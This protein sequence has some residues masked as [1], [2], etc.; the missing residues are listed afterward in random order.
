MRIMKPVYLDYNATCPVDKEV[1]A[2]MQPF[3]TEYFGNPSSMHSYGIKTKTAI[4]NARRQVAALLACEPSEIIFTSGGSE[5]NNYAIK[6]I[7]FEHRSKGRHIISSSIEHPA[8]YEVCRY[9][10]RSGFE[11]SYL[12]VDEAGLVSPA[13]VKEAIREDTILIS[14]MHANNEVGTIQP[15]GEIA[16]IARSHD[17]FFHTDAAQ[18]AGKIETHVDKLGVDLLSIAG[19]KIYAPKGVG[20]LY[21]RQGVTL[22]KLI[23]GADHEQNLR[24]GTENV[25]EIVGLGK[26]CELAMNKLDEYYEHYKKTRDYLYSLLKENFPEIRLNG[27]PVKCL[28]NT[29]S[30]SFP[31]LEASTLISRMENVAA[32]AGAACHA[33]SIDIS[34]VLKA[35]SVPPEYAMGTIRFSTGRETSMDDIAKASEE[36]STLV[37]SLMPARKSRAA[38]SEIKKDRIRL[39]HYTHGLGCACKIQPGHLEKVLASVSMPDDPGVLVGTETS[40][41][42]CVYLLNDRQ[43]IVQSLDFFTPVVDDPYSFGAIAAANALSDIYAMGA[44]PLFALNI[45]GFPVNTLPLSVLEQILRGAADKARQAGISILG[46]HTIEDNEPKFGLVV[47]GL[48]DPQKILRNKGAEAGDALILTKPIGTGILATAL[49]RGLLNGEQEDMLVSIM[50]ELNMTAAGILQKYEVHAC[51]DVTGFGLTGHLREMS[52]ASGCN[53]SVYTDRIPFIDEAKN[54]AAA[55]IIPGGTFSNLEF[56]KKDVRF[57]KCSRTMQV[58]L[59]DAQTSGGLLAAVRSDEGLPI[60]NELREAGIEDAAIIGEFTGKG[61]GIISVF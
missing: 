30:V 23:H 7:A 60:L 37:A 13:S 9:L 21:I 45:V 25:L 57:G 10:E 47:S 19:H 41:D 34:Q 12:P 33:E 36:I 49:K 61:E 35:M 15:V 32:S 6:G 53:V 5:S 50:S 24:A 44:K 26:A 8:V 3:L 46:G 39:T 17:I 27:H 22:E 2:A 51:T 40:D 56:V 59:S 48:L 28:P 4:E 11:V 42:A 58:L 43:A 55:G 31:G 14:I 1:A 18:T 29:L 20:A 52:R 54:F 16:E 38:Y